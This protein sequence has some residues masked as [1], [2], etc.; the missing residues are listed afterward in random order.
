M[1]RMEHTREI[2]VQILNDI[3]VCTETQKKVGQR[4][5]QLK[6]AIVRQQASPHLPMTA[7]PKPGRPS[8]CSIA[9]SSAGGVP[10]Y[11]GEP[12]S[13]E[14][15]GCAVPCVCAAQVEHLGQLSELLLRKDRQ[16]LPELLPEMAQLQVRGAPTE[17]APQSILACRPQIVRSHVQASGPQPPRQPTPA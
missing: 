14:A 12:V 13:R 16:L 4:P 6:L 5:V 3:A 7:A 11:S 17:P 15:R 9:Q 8:H 10:R 1:S 2:A